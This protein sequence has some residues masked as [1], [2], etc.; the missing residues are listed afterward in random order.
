M[1]LVYNSDPVISM[2]RIYPI[3]Q[4]LESPTCPSLPFHVIMSTQEVWE[5]ALLNTRCI[6]RGYHLCCFEVNTGKVFTAN[7][8]RGEH[9]NAFKVV[10]HRGQL[11]RLQS[12]LVDPL[13]PVLANI[14]LSICN[15]RLLLKNRHQSITTRILAIDWSSIIKI[16]RF[17]DIDWY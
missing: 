6:V 9:G 10:N 17:T 14:S 13:W 16:N 5:E 2:Q 1:K 8:K 3:V 12:E 15:Q 4:V 11:G 7:K